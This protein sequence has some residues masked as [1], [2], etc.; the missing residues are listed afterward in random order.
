VR[1]LVIG[2]TGILGRRVVP[3]LLSGGHEV[4]AGGR[5]SERLA[6]LAA[7]GARSVPLDVL[8]R[9][10]VT[11]AARGHDAIVNLATRVPGTGPRAFLPGAWRAMDRVRRDGS[12]IVADAAIAGGVARVVQESFAGIYPD[13]GDAWLDETVPPRPVAYNRSVMDAES[14]AR[15]VASA[16]R[17]AVVLRFALLYGGAEDAFTRDVLRL[18]QRGWLPF[19]GA[20]DGYCSMVTHDDAADA[21]VAALHAPS[22]TYNVVDDEPLTRRALADALGEIVGVAPPRIPPRWLASLGGSMGEMVAQSLR[23][24]NRALRDATAWRPAHPS[25]R[26]GWRAAAV[27][28]ASSP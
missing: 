10:G 12:A 15:R 25:G 11:R 16:G 1:I 2:A 26:E 24:S 23:I 17:V 18:A 13:G 6:S 28:S 21:V 27:R 20:R 7:L 22:G 8:D 19:L 3:L 5:S 4:T 9:D 14:S